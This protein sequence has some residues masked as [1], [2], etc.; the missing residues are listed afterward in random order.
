MEKNL[1]IHGGG[2]RCD[3][4]SCSWKDETIPWDKFSDYINAPCPECGENILTYDDFKRAQQLRDVVDMINTIP[5]EE[6]Q[7]PLTPEEIAELK[8]SDMFKDAEGLEML[9]NK[10]KLLVT[11][12]LHKQIKIT[13]VEK[14]D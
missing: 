7:K 5:A 8:A 2:L 12:D 3:N 9:D 6:L 14:P 13:K 10:G 4:T 1:T 11:M